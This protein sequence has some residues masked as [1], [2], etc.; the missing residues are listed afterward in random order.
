MDFHVFNIRR[1]LF[2]SMDYSGILWRKKNT[3]IYSNLYFSNIFIT[4]DFYGWGTRGNW[5]EGIY[6]T[7]P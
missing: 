6:F 3:C 4:Y 2:Y 1:L 5:L 7:I